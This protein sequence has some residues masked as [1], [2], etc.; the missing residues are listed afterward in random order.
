MGWE[1]RER[2]GGNKNREGECLVRIEREVK[3]G[4]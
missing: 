1:N 4:L 3:R 2:I